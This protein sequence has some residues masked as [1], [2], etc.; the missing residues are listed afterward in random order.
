MD[1]CASAVTNPIE[2]IYWPVG[3][4]QDGEY[5]VDVVYF[6]PCQND[7]GEQA[8]ELIVRVDGRIIEQIFGTLM[9]GE[10]SEIL[11]FTYP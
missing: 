3:T 6:S 11:R 4:A 10:E 5:I 2:N 8:Y 1:P 7:Q 9:P